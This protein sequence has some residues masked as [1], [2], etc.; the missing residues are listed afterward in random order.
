[1]AVAL[2]LTFNTFVAQIIIVDGSSMEPTLHNS[3]RMFVT[4]YTY[5]FRLPERGEVVILALS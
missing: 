1:V 3:E 2:A 5:R 4:R